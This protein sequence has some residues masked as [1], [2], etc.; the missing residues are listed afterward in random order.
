MNQANTLTLLISSKSLLPLLI[1][2]DNCY[3]TIKDS[4]PIGLVD[5]DSQPALDVLN[6]GQSYED[7][8][9][10]INIYMDV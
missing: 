2:F 8:L 5:G 6:N 7:S 9:S 3:H 10:N 4:D 1:S